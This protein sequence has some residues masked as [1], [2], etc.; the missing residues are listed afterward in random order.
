MYQ[1]ESIEDYIRSI[2]GY[3]NTNNIYAQNNQM[4]YKMVNQSA[5]TELEKYYPE[6]YRTIYPLVSQK[7][8]SVTEPITEELIDNMTNEIYNSVENRQVKNRTLQ[9]LIK[10]LIIRELLNRP[11]Q[12]RPRPPYLGR[13]N[14]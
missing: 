11:S 9:D 8:S 5:N 14:F 4:Q 1:D 6:I 7:C 2:L 10:I 12:N 13:L 3:P